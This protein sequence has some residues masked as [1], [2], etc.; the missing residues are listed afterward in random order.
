MT[1]QIT[2]IVFAAALTAACGSKKKEEPP[3][4][5]PPPAAGSA[6]PAGSGG[7]APTAGSAAG[8]AAPSAGSGSAAGSSAEAEVPT[9]EDFEEAAAKKIDAKNLNTQLDQM[10][11]ELGS[12]GK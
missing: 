6:N 3:V 10:E 4:T 11:K 7:V 9:Q 2:A 1:K 5:P 12:G 8:S